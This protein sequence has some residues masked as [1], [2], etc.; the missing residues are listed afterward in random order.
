LIVVIKIVSPMAFAQTGMQHQS[1]LDFV[2]MVRI[3]ATPQHPAAIQ[4]GFRLRGTRGIV[5][6]LH[7]VVGG[8]PFSAINE[9]NEVFSNLWLGSLDIEN[10]IAVLT[11]SDPR[12]QGQEGLSASQQTVA[13]DTFLHVLGHPL[14]INLHLKG[15]QAG[16]PAYVKLSV[17]IPPVAA[18]AFDHRKSPSANVQV[19]DLETAL[20]SGDSGAPVLDDAGRVVGVVDGGLLHGQAAISWAILLGAVHLGSVASLQNQITALERQPAEGLFSFELDTPAPS[21]SETI[22]WQFDQPN[23][24]MGKLTGTVRGPNG[25]LLAGATVQACRYMARNDTFG[26]CVTSA[27]TDGQ[28]KYEISVLPGGYDFYIRKPS[29][30]TKE[31]FY[32]PILPGLVLEADDT[33][34]AESGA[35]RIFGTSNGFTDPDDPHTTQIVGRIADY[36]GVAIEGAF[37]TATTSDDSPDSW[38]GKTV[39]T[40]QN[41]NFKIVNLAA[42]L[43]DLTIEAAGYR[44][45]YLI[46]VPTASGYGI[47][48]RQQLSILR[49]Q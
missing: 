39:K 12:L 35:T 40:D 21:Q 13:S 45:I 43:Y 15:V 46:A 16:N 48:V 36:S 49:P 14:G 24:R 23:P 19:L 3:P 29:Y 10:D 33:L 17:L 1:N 18:E 42:A 41:G 6:A 27:M 32:I 20:V 8:G 9:K 5:T 47:R 38:H 30:E 11:S 2:Y 7:G 22:L 44:T 31:M 28:G 26:H 37:V 4:T 34:Q 25:Q